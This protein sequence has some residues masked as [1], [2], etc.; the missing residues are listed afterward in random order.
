MSNNERNRKLRD[1]IYTILDSY[2]LKDLVAELQKVGYRNPMSLF[3]DHPDGRDA[4]EEIIEAEEFID[5][6]ERAFLI[7]A[8][9]DL[10]ALLYSMEMD[11]LYGV[12]TVE[13][14]EEKEKTRIL[15][16]PGAE[17]KTENSHNT[18]VFKLN[19]K[20]AQK[21]IWRRV[22]VPATLS[23]G[24]FHELIQLVFD[25]DNSHLHG[26]FD[27]RTKICGSDEDEYGASESEQA[28]S[29]AQVFSAEKQKISYT[30]DFGDSHDLEITL[31]KI[32]AEPCEMPRL[33]TGRRIPPPEDCGGIYQF[34]LLREVAQNKKH[35]QFRELKETLEMMDLVDSRG[36]FCEAEFDREMIEMLNS[37]IEFWR[38]N[39]L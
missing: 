27:G 31:E 35:P 9:L 36:N 19:L 39:G 30:Y 26:F 17:P 28:I 12:T 4:V 15:H 10:I 8:K 18:F 23:F 29:L 37:D 34:E 16:F 6:E 14:P 20:G 24:D 2:R 21:P 25:W 22:E 5:E 1:Q 33:I 7:P 11:E 13:Q 32:V 3:D 38:E